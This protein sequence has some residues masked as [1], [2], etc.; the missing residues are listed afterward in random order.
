MK[1]RQRMLLTTCYQCITIHKLDTHSKW[2]NLCQ[3]LNSSRI[4]DQKIYSICK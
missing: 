3:V 1:D 2:E 4:Y